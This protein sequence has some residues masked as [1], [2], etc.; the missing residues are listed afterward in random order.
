LP[1][2]QGWP[3]CRLKGIWVDQAWQLV[4]GNNLNPR[5]FRLDLENGLLLHD[6]A[7]QLLQQ[8]AAELD[9]I[10]RH[11]KLL[12]HYRQLETLRDYPAAVKTLL[13]RLKRIRLDRLL[14]RLL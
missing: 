4:T 9:N 10:R 2:S 1:S 5:A 6:P 13:G 14:N 3:Q 8:T 7:G 11:T 12:Q